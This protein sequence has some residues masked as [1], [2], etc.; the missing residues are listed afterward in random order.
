MKKIHQKNYE[1]WER[2]VKMISRYRKGKAEVET[3]EAGSE[4]RGMRKRVLLD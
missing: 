3:M 2:R 4:G 1:V